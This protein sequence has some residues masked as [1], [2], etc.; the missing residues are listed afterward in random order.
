[1][2]KAPPERA[3]FK[4]Q[5]YGCGYLRG[6]LYFAVANTGSTDLHPF[7]PTLYRGPNA[8]E[9]HIPATL[10]YVVGVAHTISKLGPAP[11]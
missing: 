9:I 2:K 4:L 10:R 3:L 5:W 11:A 8:L 6:L 7:G 1:M